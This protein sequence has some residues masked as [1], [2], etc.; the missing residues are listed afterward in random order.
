MA[1]GITAL[2]FEQRGSAVPF[3]HKPF[4][5]TRVRERKVE[6]A[7]EL[8]ALILGYAGTR[9]HEVTVMPWHKLQSLS[10]MTDRDTDLQIS[11]YQTSDISQLDPIN[12]REMALKADAIFGM[13]EERR[14]AALEV[15]EQDKRDAEKVRLS[16]IAE[17]TRECGIAK[18][19]KLMMRTNTNTLLALMSD[20]TSRS[21][22]DI[23]GL[24]DRVMTFAAERSGTT[25]D[26]AKAYLEPLVALMTPLGSIAAKGE[27]KSNGFLYN[28]YVDLVNFR[29]E[30]S[31][32]RK[33][34]IRPELLTP[35]EDT[36]TAADDCISYVAGRMDLLNKMMGHLATMFEENSSLITRLNRVRRDVAY[37][38]DGWDILIPRWRLADSKRG[39]REGQD[40]FEEVVFK[41]GAAAPRIPPKERDPN[42]EM[43]E[44]GKRA[45]ASRVKMI[46]EMHSWSNDMED[47][48][49]KARVELGRA[50]QLVKETVWSDGEGPDEGGA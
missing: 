19:D 33:Q 35:L 37:G 27:T 48:E 32:L 49:L 9:R 13:D 21:Q 47:A 3:D 34:E 46:R 26:D 16:C 4:A 28:S 14:E 17:L 12:I 39:D 6:N 7:R 38:L 43:V 50:R 31:E 2:T 1:R 40:A 41:V 8:D 24:V 10:F 45:E 11:I 5:N 36:L 42:Y 15:V 23:E 44:I 22:F 20:E 30:I 25:L 18:G 29:K